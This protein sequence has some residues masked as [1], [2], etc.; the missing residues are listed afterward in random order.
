M[1]SKDVSFQSNI[2]M[3]ENEMKLKWSAL[4]KWISEVL[5]KVTL[6]EL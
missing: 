4:K 5:G 3:R 1:F 2:T 6:S